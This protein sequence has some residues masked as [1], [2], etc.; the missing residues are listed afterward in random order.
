MLK[1]AAD[2]AG[3]EIETM[4]DDAVFAGNRR[5]GVCEEVENG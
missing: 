5:S 4:D 2:N 3:L 1:R